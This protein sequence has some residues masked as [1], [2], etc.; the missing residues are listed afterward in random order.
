MLRAV[1]EL[2]GADKGN[3]ILFVPQGDHGIDARGAAR[4]DVAS[5]GRDQ[6]E[7]ECDARKCQ[8]IGSANAK[9]KALQKARQAKPAGNAD[10][11]PDEC[12]S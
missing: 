5:R 8:R 7:Q 9:E 10:Q 1:I 6:C 3:I 4:R 12:E 2:M 11:Y